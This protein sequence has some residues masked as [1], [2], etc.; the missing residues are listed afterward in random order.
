[1]SSVLQVKNKVYV[2][3][4]LIGL[5]MTL[6]FILVVIS[7][8]TLGYDENEVLTLQKKVNDMNK[9][10]AIEL[11]KN[12]LLNQDYMTYQA[13]HDSFKQEFQSLLEENQASSAEID[14][15]KANLKSI[16]SKNIAL[17]N[18][19]ALLEVQLK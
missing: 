2:L 19:L 4:S 6:L 5:L 8:G 9:A 10:Y 7:S 3:L 18:E 12:T 1:M 15:L 13:Y 14:A 17:Q 11:E 16:E